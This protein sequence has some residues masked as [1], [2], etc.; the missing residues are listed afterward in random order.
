M[1]PLLKTVKSILSEKVGSEDSRSYDTVAKIMFGKR[2]LELASEIENIYNT[3]SSHLEV[4]NYI[5]PRVAALNVTAAEQTIK[6]DVTEH[7]EAP[8]DPPSIVSSTADDSALSELE[9][10]FNQG[11]TNTMDTTQSLNKESLELELDRFRSQPLLPLRGDP[12]QW[13]AGHHGL[14]PNLS[15]LAKKY[16]C[17][18]ATSVASERVFSKSSILTKFRCSLADEH[19]DE[20]VFLMKNKDYVIL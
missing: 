18:A 7:N 8:P 19:V 9:R 13:W 4:A 6:L 12:L 11:V 17:I 3:E 16:L 1:L 15:F 14:F 20:L 2:L 10:M 5:D